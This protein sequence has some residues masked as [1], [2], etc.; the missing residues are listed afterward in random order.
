MRTTRWIAVAVI[1]KP[2]VQVHYG[3]INSPNGILMG[4][5]EW[6]GE[7]INGMKRSYIMRN[8]G[9]T[10]EL[11]GYCHYTF[12]HSVRDELDAEMTGSLLMTSRRL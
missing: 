7:N 5:V 8:L 4:Y 2:Q 11:F 6:T 1:V 12:K 3:L 10:N 9:Q